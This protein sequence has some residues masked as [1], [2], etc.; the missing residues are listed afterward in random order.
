M[1]R[2]SLWVSLISLSILASCTNTINLA[3]IP[4]K[5]KVVVNPRHG[6]IIKWNAGTGN[7]DVKFLPKAP[8]EGGKTNPCKIS[9]ESGK[10]L[11]GCTHCTDPEIVVGSDLSGQILHAVATAKDPPTATRYLACDSNTVKM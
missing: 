7:V 1:R 6:D 10:F 2:K 3:Y 5:Q 9:V 8:C 4:D 11:Y